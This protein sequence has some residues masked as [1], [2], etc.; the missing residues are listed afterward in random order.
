MEIH[1]EVQVVI[2]NMMNIR[3][4]DK[5]EVKLTTKDVMYIAKSWIDC[6]DVLVQS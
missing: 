4:G 5:G 1:V 6:V 3:N 2:I